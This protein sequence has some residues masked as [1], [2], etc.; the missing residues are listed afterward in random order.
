MFD[1]ISRALADENYL[2]NSKERINAIKQ[3]LNRKTI[4]LALGSGAARGLAHIG[5]MKVLEDNSIPIDAIVGCSAG[6][7]VGGAYACGMS[8]RELTELAVSIRQTDII[9]Y[10]DLGITTRSGLIRGGRIR[11]LLMELTHNASFAATRVPFVAIATNIKTG[12]EKAFDNGPVWSAIRA[13]ISMPGIF[14]PH[15]IENEYFVDGAVSNPVPSDYLTALGLDVVIGVDVVP[16]VS[17]SGIKGEPNM[18][19]VLLNSFDIFQERLVKMVIHHSD[20]RI[21]PAIEGVL[22]HEFY[23]AE[24][25]IDM[26]V[27]A[28]M[29]ALDEIN[30]HISL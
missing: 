17:K 16:D 6:A 23:R 2:R 25:I 26:G 13:S 28:T 3:G 7:L 4:G 1:S 15:K 30:E 10:M 19:A 11:K 14:V 5:V 21:R 27:K 9:R 29:E 18:I 22:A 8:V 24:E 20:I 12:E